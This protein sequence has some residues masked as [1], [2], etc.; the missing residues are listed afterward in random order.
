[1][2]SRLG[3][4]L[5]DSYTIDRKIG[6]VGMA[7]VYLSRDIRHKRNVALKVLNP[8]LGA[9]PNSRSHIAPPQ[10]KHVLPSSS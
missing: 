3:T 4:A 8:K 9:V 6:A 1:M 10:R 5:E 2:D 7:T